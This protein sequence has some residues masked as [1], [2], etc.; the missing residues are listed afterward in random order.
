MTNQTQTTVAQ[1]FERWKSED[2]SLDTTAGDLQSWM[3]DVEQLG[4]PRFGET[5]TRLVPFR[6]LLA[7]HFDEENEMLDELAKSYSSESPEIAAMRRQATQDHVNLLANLDD[8]TGRLSDLEP[9]F[10]SWQAAMQEFDLL[11]IQIEQHE[12]QESENLQAM[13]P[14]K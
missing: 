3:R 8:F 9:P 14:S 10:Q 13:M 5:A 11:Y 12:D 7:K 2:R 6:T 1:I 4:V